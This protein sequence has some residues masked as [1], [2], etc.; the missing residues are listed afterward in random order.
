MAAEPIHGCSTMPMGMKTPGRG[1]H[2]T[3]TIA[4]RRSSPRAAPCKVLHFGV[5]QNPL[6]PLHGHV[7]ACL[8]SRR[9]WS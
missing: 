7:P 6:L 8:F 9:S 2:N 1:K 5:A 4:H 3:R